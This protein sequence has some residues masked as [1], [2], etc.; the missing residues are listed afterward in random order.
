MTTDANLSWRRDLQTIFNTGTLAGLTD[1]Q[2]LERIV[3]G[4][5]CGGGAGVRSADRA[6]RPDGAAA[7]AGASWAIRT[8]PRT[9]SRRRSW[10]C[11]AEAGSI[12]K[13]ESVGPWLHGVARRVAACARSAAARRRVHERRWFERRL[14]DAH[15]IDRRQSRF[16]RL[17]RRSTPS[18]IACPS[19]TAPDR[20][21]RPG[22][23][24]AR[25]G[26][27]GSSA[28]RWGPSRAG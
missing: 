2:L 12:R 27:H 22:G 25:R 3:A 8:R 17:R 7:S 1:G 18:W 4:Q 11:S 13:R 15:S 24:F 19:A 6:A 20:A 21:L 10:S 26:C 28:G 16:R 23:A 14:C 5:R 9:R